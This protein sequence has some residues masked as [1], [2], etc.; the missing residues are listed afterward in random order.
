MGDLPR[1]PVVM[2]TYKRADGEDVWG[3]YGWVVNLEFFEDEAADHEGVKIVREVWTR[4]EVEEIHLHPDECCVCE[5]P[6]HGET[7][8]EEPAS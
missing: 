3:E 7:C 1:P 4:T 5:K 2:T 8:D 6:W